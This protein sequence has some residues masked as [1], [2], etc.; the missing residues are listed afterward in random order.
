MRLVRSSTATRTSGTSGKRRV[1]HHGIDARAEIEDH[2]QDSGNS[3]SAPG[4][5]FQTA[6]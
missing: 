6:A 3:R 4:F 2:L 5:G 1:G